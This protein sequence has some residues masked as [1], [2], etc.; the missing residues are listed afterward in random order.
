MYDICT[1]YQH[2]TQYIYIQYYY[3]TVYIQSP[4]KNQNTGSILSSPQAVPHPSANATFPVNLS[5]LKTSKQRL[6]AVKHLILQGN[7]A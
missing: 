7:S 2:C 1:V 6:G 4:D 3:N 5:G